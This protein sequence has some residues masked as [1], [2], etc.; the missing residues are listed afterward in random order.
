M[1]I[2]RIDPLYV[3]VIVPVEQYGRIKSGMKGLVKPES[4]IG[5]KYTAEVIIVDKFVDA[6]SGT[7]GVRLRL[8]NPT[9]QLPPGL[10][11]KVLFLN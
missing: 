6:A 7:F 4:P 9:L 11:C 5:G 8:P 10:K 2:A 3:E 1:K